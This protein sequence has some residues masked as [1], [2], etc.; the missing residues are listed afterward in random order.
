MAMTRKQRIKLEI[1]LFIDHAKLR[2]SLV[3]CR[4][5]GHRKMI[6]DY[7]RL[8]CDRCCKCLEKNAVICHFNAMRNRLNNI[9]DIN[10]I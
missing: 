5:R 1:Q 9:R 6:D 2:L 7:G 4:F 10:D 8:C 3:I